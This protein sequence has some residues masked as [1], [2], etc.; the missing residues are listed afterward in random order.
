MKPLKPLS[1]TFLL[2]GALAAPAL[3]QAPKPVTLLN[4]S[5]DPTRELY[6]DFN[7]KFAA[8]WKGK[9][10]Q[11]I[12][13]QQSHGGSGKQARSVIDGLQA[14]V[15]TLALAADI[16][17]IAQRARLMQELPSGGA[18][19]AVRTDET[20]ARTHLRAGSGISVAALNGPNSVVLSGGER[21]IEAVAA[22]LRAD[23]V[24]LGQLQR[25]EDGLRFITHCI[26]LSDLAH[27]K[28]NRLPV[29]D[30]LSGLEAAVVQE[31]DRAV[32]QHVLNRAGN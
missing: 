18:M 10:G 7:A 8:F 12:A 19:L 17:E 9:T 2:A 5:Y 4:V 23:Y 1:F 15:V 32:R 16:D 21:Q 13:I 6:E 20:T 22:N 24:L 3:G 11:D 30:D 31:F 25:G 29:A 14:D 27:L 28:A 26:R